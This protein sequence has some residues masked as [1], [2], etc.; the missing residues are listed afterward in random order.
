MTETQTM[1]YI[2]RV[3]IAERCGISEV[4]AFKRHAA[5][6]MLEPDVIIGERERP[7]WDPARVAKYVQAFQEGRINDPAIRET[8]WWT[9]PGGTRRLLGAWEVAARLGLKPVTITMRQQRGRFTEFAQ[10]AAVLTRDGGEPGPRDV[11]GWTEDTVLKYGQHFGYLDEAGNI[12]PRE[13]AKNA[14]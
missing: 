9:A 3:G 12:V 5:G 7:G 2:N 11:E 1:H 14:A 8:D 10:P 13:T 4:V 6:L